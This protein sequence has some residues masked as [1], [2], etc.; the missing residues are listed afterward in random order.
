MTIKV[1]FKNNNLLTESDN[2]S[3]SEVKDIVEKEFRKLIRKFLEEELRDFIKKSDIKNDIADI[4][5]EFMKRLYKD[6][7]YN[8]TYIIDR[9]K[10]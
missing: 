6:M 5:K 4:T 10:L 8:D 9:I 3:K 7:S 1:T 2:M